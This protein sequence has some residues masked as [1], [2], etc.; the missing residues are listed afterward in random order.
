MILSVPLLLTAVGGTECFGLLGV[1][2][3]GKT[4]T[5]K[6]LM[7]DEAISSGN[8]YV[9]GHSVKT[10]ITKVHEKIGRFIILKIYELLQIGDSANSKIDIKQIS[11]PPMTTSA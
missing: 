5:F 6:M 3:A 8:A 9:S 4:T 7:G 1:N 2:G 11:F 10:D